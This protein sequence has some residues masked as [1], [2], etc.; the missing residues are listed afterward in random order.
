MK[1]GKVLKDQGREGMS[2]NT[3]ETRTNITRTS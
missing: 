2:R 1:K 3:M